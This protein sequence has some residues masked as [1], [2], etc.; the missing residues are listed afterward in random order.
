MIFKSL[1][2]T[3][4]S[5]HYKYGQDSGFSGVSF[6]F[7]FLNISLINK[8]CICKEMFLGGKLSESFP[9]QFKQ[10]S[11]NF[12]VTKEISAINSSTVC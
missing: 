7:L 3:N 2:V 5:E 1:S 6:L 9:D 4:T 11:P 12:E 10:T 8:L